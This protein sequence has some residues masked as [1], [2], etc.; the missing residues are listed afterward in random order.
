MQLSPLRWM[1]I[2]TDKIDKTQQLTHIHTHIH[3]YLHTY[4]ALARMHTLTSPSMYATQSCRPSKRKQG[5]IDTLRAIPWMF[6][7]TQTRL[8]LPVWMGVGTALKK[9]IDAGNLPQLREMYR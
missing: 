3:T 2:D 5:G 1:L 8:Q 4:T 6:A 9:E 7:W